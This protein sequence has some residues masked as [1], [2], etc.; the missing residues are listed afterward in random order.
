MLDREQCMT[1]A[2][3]LDTLKST[4]RAV[5]TAPEGGAGG[6][7][8]DSE[9]ALAAA[10]ASNCDTT[11]PLVTLDAPAAPA[12]GWFTTPS[13]EADVTATD[14][15]TVTELTCAC[16]TV[17]GLTGIGT[18]SASAKVT[19]TGDGVFLVDCTGKDFH[20]NAGAASGSTNT[21][22]IKIDTSPPVL[23]CQPAS[24]EVGQSGDVSAAVS[25]A[26]SGP[27]TASVSTAATT[28]T[29]GSFTV[30]MSATD[31]AGNSST[32]SCAYTVTEAADPGTTPT[33]A[34]PKG[35]KRSRS[36]P[37]PPRSH[38]NGSRPQG[39]R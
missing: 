3:V 39:S 33:P 38:R 30:T 10:G 11:P 15:R 17:S 36:Q 28:G 20:Y 4:D 21:A 37:T 29:A 2:Q 12:S 27:A 23:T 32:A 6:G 18:T 13:V 9:A 35:L 7:L 24:F 16:A 14:R 8:V 34:P 22:T 1:P 5:G 25:D 19:V 26:G 31:L